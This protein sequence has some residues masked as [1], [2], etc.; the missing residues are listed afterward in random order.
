MKAAQKFK[1]TTSYKLIYVMEVRDHAHAGL[2]KIGDA[3]VHTDDPIDKLPPNCKALNQAARERIKGYTNTGGFSY[4]L[5]HTEL[6]VRQVTRHGVTFLDSFRD[7]DVHAVLENSHIHNVKIAETTGGEWYPV[8][9]ATAKKAIEAYKNQ[10]ANLSGTSTKVKTPIVFRPEQLQA[11]EQ[12][13]AQFKVSNRMLWNAK[14]RYGKTLTALEVVR[15]MGF[16]RTIIMTH[17]PVVDKGWYEDFDKIFDASMGYRYGS[18][19]TGA[20]LQSLLE[21]GDPFVYFASIQDLRGSKKVGG[22][23]D[24]NDDVFRT[25]WDFV[26]VDEAHE[27][28][29]T[30]LGD[31]TVKAVVKENKGKTKFLALSG[32]PFNILS[33]YEDAE[34]FTWDYVM[35]QKAKRDWWATH[36][37]DSN[38]Y[39]DLPELRIYTYDLGDVFESARYMGGT[40]VAFNFR[41]FFRTWTGDFSRDHAEMPES[42]RPGDFVHEQDVKAFLDLLCTPSDTPQYPFSTEEYRD[43]F[44]HTLWMVPGVRE[45]AALKQ[46][47][48]D[49]P[50]FGSGAFRV[51][52]VAGDGDQ[53]DEEDREALGKVLGAIEKADALGNYTI[54]LSCGRLTTGVTVKEWSAVLMLSGSYS[55]SAANYLQTIFRVQSPGQIDGKAKEC[56]YVFDFA[57]DRT[58]KMVAE[59]VKASAKPGKTTEHDRIRLGAFLNFCPVIAISGS[60]MTQYDTGA[61]LQQMKRAY[62]DRVVRSGFEDQ[63]LYSEELYRLTDGDLTA[64]SDLKK[65]VG[66]SKPTKAVD[67]IEVNKQGLT[68]EEYEKLEKAR[69]K[70]KRELTEEEKEL[71]AKRKEA[72]KNRDNA[73]SILRQISV[74]MP[75]LIFGADTP[76]GKDITLEEFVQMVDDASWDEFMPK[77][78]TK[79]MFR[80]FMRF[81][82]EDV[83]IAA[84]HRIRDIA[85]RADGLEPTERVKRIAALFTYFKNPDKETVLTPWR[86]VNMHMSDCLGGWDFFDETHREVLD[87]PRFVD[88]G[89]TTREVFGDPNARILE[90][91]SK[92]GLYPLYVTYTEY[93]SRAGEEERVLDFEAKRR[94]WLET[95]ETNVF[96]VCKTP[97]AKTITRRTLLGYMGGRIQAHYF[98]NLI[99]TLK[100]KPKQF[101]DKVKRPRYWD[102]GGK[103]AIEFSAVVGNPPYQEQ[104]EGNGRANPVYHMFMDAAFKLSDKVSLI[105]PA[106]FLFN[107]GMTPKD[108][109]QRMLEDEHLSVVEYFPDAREVF[110]SAEIKGGVVITYRDEHKTLGPV[111]IMLKDE[112]QK[113]IVMKVI[114]SQGFAPLRDIVSS[115]GIFHFTSSFFEENP[116][117]R[118][119]LNKGTKDKIISSELDEFDFAFHDSKPQDGR[120][121]IQILGRTKAG[122]SYKWV[123]RDYVTENDSNTLNFY[124]VFIAEAQGSG[125]FGEALSEPII[126]VPGVGQTD[127]FLAIGQ[128]DEERE[129]VAC[130]KYLKTK[131]VRALLGTMK[132][133]QHASS[134]VWGRVPQQSFGISS[135]IDWTASVAEIDA[136]L[137]EW[138]GLSNEDINYIEENVQSMH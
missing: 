32:T 89:T 31:E 3:S 52:N 55:T 82:D 66:A 63:N 75:M 8:D 25:V 28:T 57:P 106:R 7:Y 16:K 27:G 64:F 1:P 69:K 112:R 94:L 88:R 45:A 9:L 78:V 134:A 38:P 113:P 127:T 35:E 81:Y 73:I 91:N 108:F 109:N 56:A 96:V 131:F 110:P 58:L 85:H 80:D 19:G 126:G 83:F 61:L 136:Q 34:V 6:A 103:V 115:Q 65:I 86:V 20:T 67:D 30:T 53:E 71:L 37:G 118:Y 68:D 104:V 26:I 47:M 43:M 79:K 100:N 13:T 29:Q 114:D 15:R 101:I 135:N 84:G 2:L 102:L 46:L 117:A 39:E 123:R 24:K 40:D 76:Y 23:F 138:Y 62:A 42:A 120:E 51:V 5:L 98:D 132:V 87:Q 10:R 105:T 59:A 18:K 90:I 12:T 124:K 125:K 77:G 107:Q 74:R 93:R 22:K 133:T 111:R 48:R 137:Y 50:V 128:F 95:V 41:E 54:T 130:A 122:R 49:H 97:M 33:D 99:G 36:F 17:R 92:T 116:S 121:Y 21:S 72:K 4:N 119:V 70:P 44:R 11:I 129:A 14:M 60:E